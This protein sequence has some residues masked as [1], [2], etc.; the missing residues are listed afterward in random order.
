M[1]NLNVN[2]FDH[3]YSVEESDLFRA[4]ILAQLFILKNSWVMKHFIVFTL[5]LI[6]CISIAFACA[7]FADSI[8]SYHFAL[9]PGFFFGWVSSVYVF[10]LFNE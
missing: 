10:K 9:V 4:Y 3:R 2:S 8:S 1:E 7:L 6:I 5:K